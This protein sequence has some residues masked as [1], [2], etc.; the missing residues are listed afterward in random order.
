MS[1]MFKKKRLTLKD[2]EKNLRFLALPLN[3]NDQTGQPTFHKLAKSPSKGDN[4]VD[5]DSI[6]N[7][8]D[9][10]IYLDYPATYT[11]EQK[12]YI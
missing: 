1:K 8:D 4:L 2:R 5:F 11:Y 6:I 12:E 3:T 7:M 10:C 9:T